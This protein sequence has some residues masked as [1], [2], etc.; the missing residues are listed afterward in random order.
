MMILQREIHSMPNVKRYKLKEVLKE[1]NKQGF[2]AAI[3]WHKDDL[4]LAD[5][6]YSD[7]VLYVTKSYMITRFDFDMRVGNSIGAQ[8]DY[9]YN[10]N[11]YIILPLER[12][13][14]KIDFNLSFEEKISPERICKQ[15][16]AIAEIV[17]SYNV[18]YAWLNIESWAITALEYYLQEL[19][20]VSVYHSPYGLVHGITDPELIWD[21]VSPMKDAIPVPVVETEIPV[22]LN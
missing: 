22:N 12:D 19:G 17:A 3:T 20:I 21:G 5:I 14:R 9:P 8:Y 2:A 13:Q 18:R 11:K 15:L 6:T 10:V 7:A 1:L 16:K 4:D